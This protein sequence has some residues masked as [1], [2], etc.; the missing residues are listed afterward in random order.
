MFREERGEK[1]ERRGYLIWAVICFLDCGVVPGLLLVRSV[2]L[3]VGG[4]VSLFLRLLSCLSSSFS[5]RGFVPV[6]SLPRS[7]Y[8]KLPANPQLVLL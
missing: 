8:D 6:Q 1:R 5:L 3:A 2:L 4:S 7:L